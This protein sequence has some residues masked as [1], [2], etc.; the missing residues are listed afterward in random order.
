LR[1]LF[2]KDDEFT[3]DINNNVHRLPLMWFVD[4]IDAIY[5]EFK[6][7]EIEIADEQRTHS[8]GLR[9]FAFVDINGYYIR[10]AEGAE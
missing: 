5:A 1:L 2:A 8:Y 3:N 6:N 10:I 7:R 4:D 9:E